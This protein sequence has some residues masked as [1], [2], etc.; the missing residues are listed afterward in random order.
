MNL[1]LGANLAIITTTAMAFVLGWALGYER[2]YHGR[3]AGTQVYCIVAMA[4]C[5]LTSATGYGGQWFH[6][7]QSGGSAANTTQVIA[8]LLTGI[9]FLGAGI[10]VKSNNN[11]RGLTTA[12][13]IWS[14]A[15]IGVL[16]GLDLFGAA[17]GITAI[18]IGCMSMV[19][20]LEQQLPGHMGI[21]ITLRYRQ[22]V[23]PHEEDVEAFL[24]ERGLAI[25]RDSVSIA[26]DGAAFTL[27]FLAL[28]R[29]SAREHIL[30]RVA[31]DLPKISSV[32]T[33]S[34][35]RTTRG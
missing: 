19:W 34:I 2:Y 20:R 23:H 11:I 22:G 7:A 24:H 12:S 8:S 32:E 4:S 15:A 28:A 35:S 26:F 6:L 10:I 25:Q 17:I 9:G 5:A 31:R 21:M 14:S 16:V 13:S 29:A 3:A 18:F 27:E 30:A 33:F 1:M